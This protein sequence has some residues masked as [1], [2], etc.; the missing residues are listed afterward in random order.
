MKSTGDVLS[1]W[2][3]LSGLPKFTTSMIPFLLGSV[4]AWTDGYIL[5]VPVLAIS[6]LAVFLLTN[7]SYVLNAC[8]VYDNLRLAKIDFN[9]TSGSTLHSTAVSGRFDAIVE[10]KISV[11]QAVKGAYLCVLAAFPLGLLLQFYFHTGILTLPLGILGVFVMYSY[12]RGPRLSYHGLGELVLTIGMGWLTVFA[13]YYLQ[14]HRVSWLPTI[15]A[16]PW[17]ID[18]FKL[19]LTRNIP[20]FEYDRAIN[21]RT[22]TV[23]LGKDKTASLYLPLTICSWLSFIPLLFLGV[24]YVGL[25]L[26]AFPIFFT[27]KSLIS[28]QRDDWKTEEGLASICKNGFIGYILIPVALLGI[29]ILALI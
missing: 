11:N 7:F 15:V 28:M 29:F 1:G 23:R 3:E 8:S 6:L 12:S 27:A 18:T 4:L 24:P 2:V 21:R 19:K 17:V 13:G 20:D 22:L 10:G 5:D 14:A 26:L 25:V 9:C 16:L